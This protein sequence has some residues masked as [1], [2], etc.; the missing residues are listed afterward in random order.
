MPLKRNRFITLAVGDKRVNRVLERERP[1]PRRVKSDI[2]NIADR[3]PQFMIGVYRPL[4][5][6]EESF[7]MSKPDLQRWSIYHHEC[8]SI[9]TQLAIVFPALAF[10]YETETKTDWSIKKV[11][12]VNSRTKSV[13]SRRSASSLDGVLRSDGRVGQELPYLLRTAARDGGWLYL[14]CNP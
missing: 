10:T 12:A 14:V 6:I 13:A 11:L 2:T 1:H 8:E 7:R 4:W 9:E 5:H 3:T